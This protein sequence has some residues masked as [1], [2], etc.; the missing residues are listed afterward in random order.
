M[1]MKRYWRWLR[2]AA[3]AL[4]VVV[5]GLAL[6]A[7]GFDLDRAAPGNPAAT[8]ADLP[9]LADP[10]PVRGRVLAVVS[11]TARIDE[12]RR[13]GGYELTELARAYY[14]FEAN[15]YA[16]DIASPAGGTP[17]AVIDEDL[18]DVDHAFLNDADAQAR[19][20]QTLRLAEVDAALYDGVYFVGGKGAMADFPHNTDIARIVGT[21][22]A[23]G[24]VVGAVCHG[25]AAL[26]GITDAHGEPWLAGRRLTAFSNREERFL[27]E[28]ADRVFG[29][30]LQDRLVAADAV[31]DEG[32]MYL[33]NTLVD[34]RLVTGQNPWAT[35]S[36]AEAMIRALRHEPV[37]R[38]AGA[39]E[40]AVTVLLDYHLRG[41]AAAHASRER[42][43]GADVRLLLMHALIAAMRGEWRQALQ[44]QWLAHG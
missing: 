44:L 18:L 12:G 5:A 38:A 39:D 34:G 15:G 29:Q 27:I 25:P 19:L 11:S 43:P 40:L 30:L 21:I 14:V 42:L 7:A 1:A 4:L 22:D 20:A 3:L 2:R 41:Y 31:F 28:D 35:W 23:R 26:L 9:W 17:P 37:P 13:K 36:V 24:G 6:Y 33:D 16:V 10:A 8:R 32:P